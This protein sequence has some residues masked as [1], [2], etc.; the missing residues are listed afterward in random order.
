MGA[1]GAA[2]GCSA[3]G[4]SPTSGSG[5]GGSAPID[6]GGTGGGA[7]AEGEVYGHSDHTLFKLEPVAKT[8]TTVGNFDC[9]MIT[10]PGSGEG[11]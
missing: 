5:T 3:A 4:T 10:L 9:V 6:A 2:F 7:P 1:I 8:I 11:M